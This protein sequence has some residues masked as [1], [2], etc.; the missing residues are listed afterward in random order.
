MARYP[1][2]LDIL[3]GEYGEQFYGRPEPAIQWQ[4]IVVRAGEKKW[5]V[6]V[7]F[8]GKFET[9][10]LQP[11]A[12]D[13]P[14][15]QSNTVKLQQRDLRS[16]LFQ[17]F[18]MAIDFRNFSF[19][20]NVVTELS[21]TTAPALRNGL[22]NSMR[23]FPYDY[24]NSTI[25][26]FSKAFAFLN[27]CQLKDLE[28]MHYPIHERGTVP[29]VQFSDLH[30]QEPLYRRRVFKVRI[31]DSDTGTSY[32]Y[33]EI[34]KGEFDVSEQSKVIVREMKVLHQFLDVPEIVKLVAVVV[35]QNP[36]RSND[37]EDQPI[38]RG[39]LLEYHARGNLYHALQQKPREMRKWAI[40]IARGLQALHS[41]Y[42]THMD[43]KPQNIVVS[44]ENNAALIDV[45][46]IGG[47]TTTWLAPELIPLDRDLLLSLP[48]DVRRRH[49]I[50]AYGRVLLEIAKAADISDSDA[51]LVELIGE[52]ASAL[53]PALRISLREA[54][55]R[56]ERA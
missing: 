40:Q 30:F 53:D 39:L 8:L 11:L 2:H 4:P 42:L 12:R 13:W 41:E 26:D 52:E 20:D 43:V 19:P 29:E 15:D 14:N 27:H 25:T 36:Y 48:F 17:T 22:Q 1:Y 50:W 3:K 23:M 9:E 16:R 56:L 24:G 35:S 47:V 28:T 55:S 54:I 10:F 46:G 31:M 32:V 21:F 45:S 7:T 49:D 33:K 37:L 18:V 5:H 6:K 51:E 34:E 38:V 44:S